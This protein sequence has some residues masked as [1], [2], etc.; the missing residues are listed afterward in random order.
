MRRNIK[1][2]SEY[3]EVLD[4]FF[5]LCDRDPLNV[6]NGTKLTLLDHLGSIWYHSEPSE[7]RG[8]LFHKKET[9]RA[10]IGI[11]TKLQQF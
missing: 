2:Q 6:L 8:Y 10:L 4:Q 7:I 11:L 1:A 9:C 5:C 3:C